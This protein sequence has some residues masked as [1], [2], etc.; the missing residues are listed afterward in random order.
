MLNAIKKDKEVLI[1]SLF[2]PK[3]KKNRKLYYRFAGLLVSEM[4]GIA[5]I[6][7]TKRYAGKLGTVKMHWSP[8]YYFFSEV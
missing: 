2:R 7:V 5:E 1:T 3:T 8:E 4:K 6:I